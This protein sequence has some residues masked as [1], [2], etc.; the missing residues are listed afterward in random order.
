MIMHLSN[1]DELIQK[2]RNV[3]PRNYIIEAVASYRAGAYR[4]ALITTWIAVCVDIIEKVK[5]LNASGDGAA[6]NIDD[7]LHKISPSDPSAMLAFEKDILE[8]ACDQLELITVIEK[9]HLER[10]KEDRNICAHPTFSA[11]GSQ[12]SPLAELALSYIVQASNYLLIHPPVRGKVVL[13]RLFDLINEASFPE[14]EEKAFIVLSSENNL[15]RV[16]GSS[17]RNLTIILLK[18]LFRDD[19]RIH[20]N[21]LYKIASALGAISRLYPEVH[22]EV[23]DSKLSQMLSD[24][25]D[26]QLKRVFPYLIRR[27]EEWSKIEQA[28]K[29]RIE[30]L[31][32]S[33]SVDELI[34]YRLSE[35]AETNQHINTAFQRRID[36]LDVGEKGKIIS[37]VSSPV[38]KRHAIEL[39]KNS[40]SFDT[41][42]YRA[43]N[44][45]LP[46]GKYFTS[47]EIRSILEG[48]CNN[49]GNYGYNQIL[50]AGSIDEFFEQFYRSTKEKDPNFRENW[51]SFRERITEK[52][53]SYAGL[54]AAMIEDGLIEPSQET[55]AEDIPPF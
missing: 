14:D 48:A 27:K 5:E 42:E 49:T 7:R 32:P 4:T 9:T 8:I 16:R 44:F 25:A 53:F 29:I 41:A 11:D 38:L 21:T 51:L 46:L 13:E 20:P 33:M 26:K 18:R 1:L 10:L 47:E 37:S 43:R 36:E 54:D 35:Y 55:S 3:H 40:S 52:R 34:S 15:G 2:I 50:P 6:K 28:V 45:I 17:V 31:I 39:F 19:S 22:K 30:G 23:I 12:F 24:A